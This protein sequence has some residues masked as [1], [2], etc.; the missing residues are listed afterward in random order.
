[1]TAREI[2]EKG[3]KESIKNMFS[4][5]RFESF[6]FTLEE[7]LDG[8]IIVPPREENYF[9]VYISSSHGYVARP[10]RLT[11]MNDKT[12]FEATFNDL[13]RFEML[14]LLVSSLSIWSLLK[15]DSKNLK[16]NY[17]AGANND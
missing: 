2:L 6:G 15:A 4:R 17:I 14:S 3:F 7:T 5:F 16:H 8:I 10:Y 12:D 13:S 11:I 9:R 1:M